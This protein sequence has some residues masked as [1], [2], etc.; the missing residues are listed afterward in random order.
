MPDVFMR[1]NPNSNGSQITQ[2]IN[3]VKTAEFILFIWT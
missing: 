1:L 2:N 3:K